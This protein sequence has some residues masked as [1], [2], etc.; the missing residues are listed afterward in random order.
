[1]P[2]MIFLRKLFSFFLLCVVFI[3]FSNLT[4]CGAEQT[5]ETANRPSSRILPAEQPEDV[6]H[7][8][9]M[10]PQQSRTTTNP[11]GVVLDEARGF[12]YVAEP[13]CEM[14]PYCKDPQTQKRMSFPTKIGK[15]ALADG[16]FIKDFPQ[17]TLFSNPLFVAVNPADGHIW[18]TEPNSDA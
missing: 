10:K 8:Q 13:G 4:A 11:W 3:C 17:P 2:H 1:M 9:T 18:F 6:K 12:V 7:S 5:D 15:Y 14:A 16:G